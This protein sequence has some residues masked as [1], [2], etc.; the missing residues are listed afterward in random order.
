MTGASDPRDARVV[1][2]GGGLGGFTVAKEL[3][4]RG[5]RGPIAVVDP[6]GLPYDRPPL[7]KGYL[8]G[9][10]TLDDLRFE[11]ADWYA[12]RGIDVVEDAATALDLDD[13]AV[14]VAGGDR[15]PADR[16]VLATGGR[17]RPLPLDGADDPRVHVLRT[18][19]DADRL[20]AAIGEGTR[21]AIVGGGLIGAEAASTAASLGARVTLIEPADPPLVPAVGPELARRLHDMHEEREVRVRTALPASLELADDA[22]RIE[23]TDGDPIEADALLVGIGIIPNTGLA[24]SAGLDVDNGVLVDERQRTADP[25]V[26]A[27]GDIARLRFADGALARRHEHWDNAIA[28]G[29]RAAA[30]IVD[31]PEPA[32][33][34]G[35]FW[36]DRYGCHV[37]GVGEMHVDGTTVLRHDRD[38]RP[39]AAFRLGA[40]GRM[41]GAAAIDGGL[42]VRAARRII[43][44]GAVVDPEALADP[45]VDLKRLA[46]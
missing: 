14:V 17:A 33:S 34:A 19:D 18:S 32:P 27:V 37:E 39:T 8:S 45:A 36:S 11:P 15:L 3:R 9:E 30:A 42:T 24:E 16:I 23:L 41:L 21:L 29:V 25:R 43:D 1:I 26:L 28:S 7:S 38:G 40:D 20:R 4:D 10:R 44:R 31:D 5:H 35:W 13:L 2:V 46:R 6:A 22:V 12:E